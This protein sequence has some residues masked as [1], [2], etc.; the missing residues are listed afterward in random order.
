MTKETLYQYD[1]NHIRGFGSC[2][3]PMTSVAFKLFGLMTTQSTKA[4]AEY[5][6][7]GGYWRQDLWSN[8]QDADLHV[9]KKSAEWSNVNPS[10]LALQLA[11]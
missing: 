9:R 4:Q 11:S 1:E 6:F 8:F 2:K 5:I 7:S 3:L 10:P